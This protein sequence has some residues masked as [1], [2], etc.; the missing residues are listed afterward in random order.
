MRD[1]IIASPS[2]KVRAQLRGFVADMGIMGV[3][4]CRSASQTLDFVRR[5][6]A[7]IICQRLT[8]MAPA[9]MLRLLPPGAD[10][11]L[12]ISSAQSPLFGMSN[13]QCM[14]LPIS[15]PELRSCIEKLLRSSS[16]SRIRSNGQRNTADQEIINKAKHLYMKVNGVSEEDAY[17]Y[18]RRRSMNESSSI[19]ATARHV[20]S[21]LANI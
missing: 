4:E 17:A 15:R 3:I 5:L 13:V 8:D 14:T 18:I 10:M 9:A 16:E 7:I 2:D 21:E 1:I 12:L 19:T 11:I 20:L 6:P